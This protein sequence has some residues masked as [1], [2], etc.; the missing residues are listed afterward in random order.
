MDK[1]GHD[2]PDLVIYSILLN[3]YIVN[4]PGEGH[5]FHAQYGY[6]RSSKKLR[7]TWRILC[8]SGWVLGDSLESFELRAFE[9]GLNWQDA[10]LAEILQGI[11]RGENACV[12][13]KE[14]SLRDLVSISSLISKS[15]PTPWIANIML[16]EIGMNLPLDSNAYFSNLFAG[17]PNAELQEF[18][19]TLNGLE[20][21]CIL[22]DSESKALWLRSY[23]FPVRAVWTGRSFMDLRTTDDVKTR[24]DLSFRCLITFDEDRIKFSH[25][26]RIILTM[27]TLDS[28]L[29]FSSKK[30]MSLSWSITLDLR[31]L[32][33]I[34]RLIVKHFSGN[35]CEFIPSDLS[36]NEYVESIH[37]FDLAWFPQRDYYLSNS[38]GRISDLM[39]AGVPIISPAG[40]F[41]D[42]QMQLFYPG[43]P[44]Y[45]NQSSLRE[46]FL[47]ALTTLHEIRRMYTANQSSI[48]ARFHGEIQI[49]LLQLIANANPQSIQSSS[50][51]NYEEMTLFKI[52]KFDFLKI[53]WTAI[54]KSRFSLQ[55]DIFK[56]FRLF[57][58]SKL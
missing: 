45:W 34:Q 1:L 24:D 26:L 9:E 13:V 22:A 54:A 15:S 12:F 18:A 4:N 35:R 46:A 43:W 38:S 36:V 52:N 11:L 21:L 3:P 48:K 57:L 42:R 44:T 14:A 53:T 16:Q 7:V 58:K 55:Y 32:N 40:T 27:N 5:F 37:S 17:L 29:A 28:L 8:Q 51:V 39:I 20:N 31:K 23:G 25:L 33:R 2:T 19:Q 41:G 50:A 56:Y 49:E 6:L 47:I 30:N 10:L